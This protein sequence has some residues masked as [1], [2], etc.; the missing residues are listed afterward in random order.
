VTEA[1]ELSGPWLSP[2]GGDGR[3]PLYDASHLEEVWSNCYY[4]WDEPGIGVIFSV[5][6]SY[7]CSLSAIPRRWD[8]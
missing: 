2:P 1:F 7:H 6:L 5:S 3:V 8:I 4:K